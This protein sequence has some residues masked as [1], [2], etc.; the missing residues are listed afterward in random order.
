MHRFEALMA[1]MVEEIAAGHRPPPTVAEIEEHARDLP[2]GEDLTIG[3][4]ASLFGILPT[5]I[6]YYE[7]EG[8]LTVDR[9]PNGHR[10]FD[11]AAV[12][13]LLLVHGMRLSDMPIREIARLRDLLAETGPAAREAA[14]ELLSAHAQD[15][16][17]RIAHLQIALAITEHKTQTLI[18]DPS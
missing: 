3:E 13:E 10:I 15:T 8:L 18:G 12:G 16:R 4:V 14:A 9:R 17:R 2:Q 11:R 6:R 5:T 1:S 7:S